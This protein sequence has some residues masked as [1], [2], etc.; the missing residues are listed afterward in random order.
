[1]RP[2]LAGL[3]TEYGF[4]VEGRG[5]EDQVEDAK[6]LVRSHPDGRPV[7]WDD[8]FESPRNDL[9]GFRLER[10]SFDPEDAR[11]DEGRTYGPASEVRSDRLL[12][13]GARLYNDHGHPEYATPETWSL[14]ELALHDR[15]GD[16]T[17][18]EA[19]RAFADSI[20]R[21][22]RVYKNNTDYHSASYGTHESYLVPRSVPVENLVAALTPL[23]VAR[24]VLCGA[25]KVGAEQGPK[26]DF[27]MS[28]RADFFS[29]A[30]NAETLYRRPVFNT[31]DEPH[32]DPAKWLRLHV[33]CG[34]SNLVSTAVRTKAALVKA[35]L[36]LLEVGE[37]PVWQ[38]VDP[39]KAIKAV[40]RDVDAEGRIELTGRSW[41]TPR[42]VLE[43][44]IEAFLRS[45]EG[46]GSPLVTEIRDVITNALGLLEA[47]FTDPERFARSV[48]WAAKRH[49]LSQYVESEG[50]R[51]SD[52]SLQA[53]DLE[54][55]RLDGEGGL[56]H[57]LRDEGLVDADPEG[58]RLNELHEDT[59]ARA[60]S[61]ALRK[62]GDRIAA[63]SWGSITFH[64]STGERT[65]E[66]PPDAAY[67]ATIEACETVEALIMELEAR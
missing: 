12:P 57:A 33:I 7:V 64:T 16:M 4:S 30:V 29:E 26:C 47:R 13:N 6:A 32:A 35:A 63:V 56:F 27:Q 54:Y 41:T 50:V 44:Y 39:V 11:F 43:S 22:V 23:F 36:H 1:M 67:P 20:G 66:L 55:H 59:R 40:S 25:G 10:L 46:D 45:T 19:A 51:W 38:F 37:Q 48:D 2:V 18:V 34:E 65:V 62:F 24:Q 60:R 21:E 53:L 52:P 5:A 9:R 15:A 17:V 49:L 28:Q 42:Q 31:R 8:R 3:D 61:V 14:D 58:A